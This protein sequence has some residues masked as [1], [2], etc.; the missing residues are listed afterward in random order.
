MSLV[1]LAIRAGKNLFFRTKVLPK[2]V[3]LE[4]FMSK[5]PKVVDKEVLEIGKK[6]VSIYPIKYVSAALKEIE[7]PLGGLK[8]KMYYK[9]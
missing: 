8:M 4:Q 7:L 3:V 2:T 5:T 6:A 1:S 9:A